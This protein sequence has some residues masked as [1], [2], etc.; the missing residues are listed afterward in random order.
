MKNICTDDIF[1][2]TISIILQVRIN[3]FNISN[4]K[5]SNIFMDTNNNNF[6]FEYI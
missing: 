3:V 5:S 2:K 4:G 1:L 6:D